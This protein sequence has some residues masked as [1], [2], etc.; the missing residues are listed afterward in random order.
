MAEDVEGGIHISILSQQQTFNR[1]LW[2]FRESRLGSAAFTV[3]RQTIS[4]RLEEIFLSKLRKSSFIQK[5]ISVAIFL[6]VLPARTYMQNEAE[7][8]EEDKYGV[9]FASD[10]EVCKVV[11]IEF[12]VCEG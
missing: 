1:L 2:R 12:Q 11:A 3:Y 4:N 10:C 7:T 5:M 6:L 8:F 9:K